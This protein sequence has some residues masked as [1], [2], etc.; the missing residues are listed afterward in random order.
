MKETKEGVI[1][2]MNE[3]EIS[4]FIENMTEDAGDDVELIDIEN[5]VAD[6]KPKK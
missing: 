6:R 5:E 1:E 4:D 2:E 3:D